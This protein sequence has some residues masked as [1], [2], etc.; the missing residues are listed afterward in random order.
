MMTLTEL[1]DSQEQNLDN[2]LTLLEQEFDLLKQR[3]ALSLAEIA[4][5]KQ[6]Q[7][8]AIV[9]LDNVIAA[10]PDVADLKGSLLSRQ[11]AL[12]EK[13]ALCQERN[14]VNGHLIEMTLSA[15][16]RLATTL[17]QLRDKNSVTYDKNGQPRPGRAGLNIKA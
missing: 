7:L 3:Q 2:M 11:E 8:E 10:H 14:E 13:M 6:Q 12:R 9:A 15:N 4:T 17:L 16:R 1:L 5:S